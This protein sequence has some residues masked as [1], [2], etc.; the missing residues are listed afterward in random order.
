MAGS[1]GSLSFLKMTAAL[2]S[3]PLFIGYILMI[4][5]SGL[6]QRWTSPFQLKSLLVIHNFSC[7]IANAVTLFGFSNALIINGSAY[8]KTS[9]PVFLQAFKI[10][11]I[12]KIVELF[13][14]V[15]L[16][17]RHRRSQISFLHVYYRF[18]MLLL[19]D[20]ARLFSPWPSIA[21]F[22]ALNSLVHV[23]LYFYYG[24]VALTPENPPKWDK[25]LTEMQI[26]AFGFGLFIAVN[27]YHYHKFCIYSILYIITILVLFLNFYFHA[28][29][30]NQ[31][32]TIEIKTH[33][34]K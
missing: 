11:W 26:F 8:G 21:T 2:P 24:L 20:V 25:S 29:L 3:I 15:Y 16:V 23:I 22:L 18:S 9:S 4:V 13:D 27:G 14:T 33:K 30:T 5:V 31:P 6:W 12:I 28:Y 7:C 34:K 1:Q 17:L 10:Y 32:Q 19:C